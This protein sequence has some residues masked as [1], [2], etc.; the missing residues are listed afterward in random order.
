MRRHGNH[1]LPIDIQLDRFAIALNGNRWHEEFGHF[2]S[3]KSRANWF[4]VLTKYGHTHLDLEHFHLDSHGITALAFV[5]HHVAMRL[6]IEIHEA[7]A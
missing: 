2:K 3:K 4:K 6:V 7:V 1:G 5:T